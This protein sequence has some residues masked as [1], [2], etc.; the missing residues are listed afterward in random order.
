END[1]K[2]PVL[3]VLN[4]PLKGYPPFGAGACDTLVGIDAIQLPLGVLADVLGEVALL[5]GKGVC[6]V[7][8][9]G[10]DSAIAGH[11]N[12]SRLPFS[13]CSKARSICSRSNIPC[14]PRAR[15]RLVRSS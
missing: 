3:G 6:L 1:A 7:L 8:L 14:S 12:H 5:S 15:S 10:G 9:V 11:G 13:S 2:F 4:H